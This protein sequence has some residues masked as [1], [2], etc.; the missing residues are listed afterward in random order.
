MKT[1]ARTL[2]AALALL[3]GLLP[4][5]ALA[6][7]CGDWTWNPFAD[8]CNRL[9]YTYRN[10]KNELLVSGYSWHLPFTWTPEKRA[11]LNANAWGA[12]WART[13]DEG[14][15]DSHSV[16]VLGFSDSHKHLQ[17][18]VGYAYTR[19]WGSRDKLQGGLGY[20]AM[21]VQRP[22]IFNGIPFP[23]VLPIGALR[24]GNLTLNGSFIPTLNG[25]INHGSTLYI[26]GRYTFD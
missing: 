23:A 2:L 19:Y 5:T 25:G 20:A 6:Q 18:Q 7:K 13:Y 14:D 15:G 11:E 17:A 21:I 9:T 8:N 22:D 24:S 12:G 3:C 26:F 10:G 4:A 1:F 16:F